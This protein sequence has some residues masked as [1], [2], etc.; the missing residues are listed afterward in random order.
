MNNKRNKDNKQLCL[1]LRLPPEK[2][3]TKKAS[4]LQQSVDK[5]VVMPPVND[6]RPTFRERV[7][8]DLVRTRVMIPE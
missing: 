8:R 5:S 4:L 2:T 1:T 6:K 7:I 3:E